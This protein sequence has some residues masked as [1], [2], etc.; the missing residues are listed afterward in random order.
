MG[1]G[2]KRTKRGKIF[3][4]SHGNSRPKAIKMTNAPKST[5]TEAKSA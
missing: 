1:K 4:G 2:D 3:Q 5:A